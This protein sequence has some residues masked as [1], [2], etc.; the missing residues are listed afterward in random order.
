MD[1]T[2]SGFKVKK[3]NSQVINQTSGFYFNLIMLTGCF[4][5]HR[6]IL[7]NLNPTP[8]YE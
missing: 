6:K 5:Y 8:G 7:H 1:K 2:T 3:N 4:W